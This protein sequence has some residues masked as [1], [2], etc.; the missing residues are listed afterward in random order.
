MISARPAIAASGKPP[1]TILPRRAQV[2]RDAVV[3]LGAAI[4]EA[5]AGHDLVEDQRD[6][7]FLRDHVAQRLEEA[8][9]GRD[10]ALE[11]LD[12]DAGQ[13]V[14]VLRDQVATVVDVVEGATSISSCRLFGMPAESGIGRGKLPGRLGA[15]L[16]SP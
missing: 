14:L 5:E 4:G 9:L 16:I 1:P 11:R 12:D 15:R 7:V 3:F 10:Q 6:A 13:L 2:G 8:G